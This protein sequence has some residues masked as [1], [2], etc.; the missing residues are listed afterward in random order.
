MAADTPPPAPLN[1]IGD[2]GGGAL[3]L[4]LGLLAGVIEAR[5]S[6]RGQVVDAAIVDGVAAMMT[7]LNGLRAGG[8]RRQEASCRWRA[9]PKAGCVSSRRINC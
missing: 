6:G 9:P 2:F 3:F 1:L 7:S 5:G 4:A 8:Q